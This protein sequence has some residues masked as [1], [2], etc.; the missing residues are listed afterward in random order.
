MSIKTIVFDFGKV[1]GHFSHLQAARQLAVYGKAA[2]PEEIV[3][4][5][6]SNELEEEYESGRMSS[7]AFVEQVCRTFQLTCT[8]AEFALAYSDMFAP[9][10]TVC[11]LLPRLKP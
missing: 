3:T 10:D 4:L 8:P 2:A 7:E 6:F 11:A 1:I 9:N 5:L